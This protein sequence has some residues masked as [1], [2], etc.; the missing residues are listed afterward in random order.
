M[1]LG[2]VIH[3]TCVAVN[4]LETARERAAAA[5]AVQQKTLKQHNN[6]AGMDVQ[7]NAERSLGHI[8]AGQQPAGAAARRPRPST[9]L[10]QELLAQVVHLRREAC[11]RVHDQRPQLLTARHAANVQP[12]VVA[13][14]HVLLHPRVGHVVVVPAQ[15]M[16]QAGFQVVLPQWCLQRRHRWGFRGLGVIVV[17]PA[18]QGAHAARRAP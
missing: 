12:V 3:S 9:Y 17:V 14:V 6:P 2:R 7:T 16:A 13:L 11:P 1:C 4:M 15:R 8:H 18:Q 10:R 5:C